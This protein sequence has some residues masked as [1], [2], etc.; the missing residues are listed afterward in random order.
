MPKPFLKWAGGKG[1]LEKSKF[2][3]VLTRQAREVT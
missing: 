2:R 1:P 3:R